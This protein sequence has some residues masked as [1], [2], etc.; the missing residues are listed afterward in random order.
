MTSTNLAEYRPATSIVESSA[1]EY[2]ILSDSIS[3]DL[4]KYFG[5]RSS[6]SS[7]FFNDLTYD[8]REQLPWALGGIIDKDKVAH[9]AYGKK[10]LISDGHIQGVE[11]GYNYLTVLMT[12]DFSKSITQVRATIRDDLGYTDHTHTKVINLKCSEDLILLLADVI[13]MGS[14]EN[15]SKD[16]EG[17]SFKAIT[18]SVL[19][20]H[21]A[22][23]DIHFEVSNIPGNTLVRIRVDGDLIDFKEYTYDRLY[24]TV[25]VAY[26]I[27]G[28][29]EASG[30]SIQGNNLS[31]KEPQ[32][33]KF[34]YTYNDTQIE[35]RVEFAPRET[36]GG[37]DLVC[38]ITSKGEKSSIRKLDKAGYHPV[39]TLLIK[40]HSS[41]KQGNILFAG[42]TG[43]GKTQSMYSVIDYL[44]DLYKSTRKFVTA[45]NPIEMNLEGVSQVNLEDNSSASDNE[46]NT[47]T[48]Q[49]ERISE[50][51][52]RLDP[53]IMGTGEIRCYNSAKFAI[54]SARTGHVCFSTIHAA[55]SCDVP[56]RLDGF[57]VARSVYQ[58]SN[59]L[60]VIIAQSL[61]RTVC[62]SCSR[63]YDELPN[64]SPLVYSL[65]QS[66]SSL[67][68]LEYLPNIRFAKQGG[69][70]EC[71]YSVDGRV[72]RT[73]VAEVL[74]PDQTIRNLWAKNEDD[75]AKAH[76]LNTG[77]FTKLEHAIYKMCKGILDP[78][79]IEREIDQLAV[80]RLVREE[81]NVSLYHPEV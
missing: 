47:L 22:T 37:G 51:F 29:D 11:E 38:R 73:P 32:S 24:E 74:A 80:S 75:L 59:T 13:F 72:G 1:K 33:G 19:E 68:L 64:N 54:E 66:L 6:S 43:S 58:S 17:R 65:I 44:Q 61:V 57:G 71:N 27:I 10:F 35:M 55:S 39:Q 23:S 15:Q 69:C 79:M 67:E 14:E 63:S 42:V 62:P 12:E 70:E 21:P 18:A 16:D 41:K 52:M 78:E 7:H 34:I 20:S 81:L 9:P 76:W 30:S 28:G 26:N 31:W 45:E 36:E 5:S 3:G 46:M 4:I 48:K 56:G 25:D 40:K 60:T 2:D 50:S 53:D 49:F 8:T 77:G